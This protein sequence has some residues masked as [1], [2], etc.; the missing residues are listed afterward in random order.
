MRFAP[1][2]QQQSHMNASCVGSCSHARRGDEKGRDMGKGQ[3]IGLEAKV[4]S[5]SSAL[6]CVMLPYHADWKPPQICPWTRNRHSPQLARVSSIRSRGFSWTLSFCR[7]E[8]IHVMYQQ[9]L[10]VDD[11]MSILYSVPTGTYPRTCLHYPCLFMYGVLGTYRPGSILFMGCQQIN[12]LF[13]L[14]DQTLSHV[15]SLGCTGPRRTPDAVRH[16]HVDSS[17]AIT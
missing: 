1:L 17:A 3:A 6:L 9:R 7:T 16:G 15:S 5:M 14:P 13:P 10:H 4:W 11:D 2:R 8:Y 12:P